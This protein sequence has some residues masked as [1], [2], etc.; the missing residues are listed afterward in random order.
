M[1]N[2]KL[3]T[4]ILAVD[5]DELN[6]I[7][8]ASSL[9]FFDICAIAHSDLEKA[10]KLAKRFDNCKGYDDY[11]QMIIAG[12]LDLLI[13]TQPTHIAAEHII[14]AIKK[15]INIFKIWPGGRDF[16]EVD[17]L[18]NLAKNNNII[19]S[20][21]NPAHSL[22]S[23]SAA[24]DYIN[25]DEFENPYL[26][27]IRW[28][29]SAQNT[30]QSWQRDPEL[31]GGGVL[32]YDAYQP[33]EFIKKTFGLPQQV[34]SIKIT[35]APD[36]Q[37]RMYL[38]EDTAVAIM[39]FSES[40]TAHLIASRTLKPD[41][42]IIKIY[43]KE[44][45]ISVEPQKFTTYDDNGGVLEQFEFSNPPENV[46]KDGLINIYRKIASDDDIKIDLIENCVQTMAVIESCYL[47]ART[48]MPEICQKILQ[49]TTSDS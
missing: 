38:V 18:T 45:S 42:Q 5:N 48:S 6:I 31:A 23:F 35:D 7:E 32:L 13:V 4:A 3:K 36:K 10:S 49:L 9:D 20:V 30:I 47:S 22:S 11:R 12:D 26:I 2:K 46:I 40:L 15:K 24:K 8:I 39:K 37:Q 33:I 43:G 1:E 28:T 41:E 17:Q 27:S 19:F 14:T 16:A 34:Y 44:K 25:S 21:L 29:T